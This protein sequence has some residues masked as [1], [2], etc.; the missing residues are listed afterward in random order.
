MFSVNFTGVESFVSPLNVKFGFNCSTVLSFLGENSK[1][2]FRMFRVGLVRCCGGGVC[3]SV[4]VCGGG[5]VYA[6]L[7][8]LVEKGVSMPA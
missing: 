1:H 8:Y 3:V 5:G 2:P 7:M 6:C 4:C